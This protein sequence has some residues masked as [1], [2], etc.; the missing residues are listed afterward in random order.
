M[1]LGTFGEGY[2]N[3]HHEFQH[4]Y[5]NGVKWWQWDPTK[6]SI[7]LLEKLGLVRSLRRVPEEK[8][9]LAQVSE[10]RRRVGSLLESEQRPLP[11]RMRA[12]LESSHEKLGRLSAQWTA[13]KTEYSDRA[14]EQ[15]AQLRAAVAEMRRELHN[16]LRHALDLLELAGAPA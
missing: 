8:I 15:I 14:D 10:A 4:D 3:Y 13:L 16:E 5:R 7:L 1:A 6:W 2:H 11:E 12:L 9:L